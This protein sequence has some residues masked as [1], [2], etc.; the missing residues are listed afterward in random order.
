MG[1]TA[2]TPIT[3]QATV[4]YED[5]NGNPLQALS[6]IVSTTVSQVA[7]VSVTPDNS[8]TADPG[9][10]VPY[11]HVVENTGNGPDTID[12]TAS[13]ST[14]PT[15]VQEEGLLPMPDTPFEPMEDESD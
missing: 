2:G 9:D 7:G 5:A 14:G 3:N 1:T 6:N 10:S 8:Q 4:D 13:T 11:L 12:V 15:P